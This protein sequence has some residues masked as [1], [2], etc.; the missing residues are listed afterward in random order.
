M[1]ISINKMLNSIHFIKIPFLVF[2]VALL[3][4]STQILLVTIIK[5][6]VSK[7]N[8]NPLLGSLLKVQ[9]ALEEESGG[10]NS[11]KYS[12]SIF[13]SKMLT[14]IDLNYKTKDISINLTEWSAKTIQ[15]YMIS[16]VWEKKICYFLSHKASRDSSV[17]L[18]GQETLLLLI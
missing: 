15:R 9:T 1:N 5:E 7:V 2:L 13:W 11:H 18:A 6:I 14:R 8:K 16:E 4:Y 17:I 10:L 3:D 12:T